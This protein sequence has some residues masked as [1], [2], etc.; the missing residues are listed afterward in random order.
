MSGWIDL[1]NLITI[2]DRR[3]TEATI[4]LKVP[5]LSRQARN[6]SVASYNALWTKSDPTPQPPYRDPT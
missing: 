2:D 3:K 1:Q 4:A 5:R 6:A